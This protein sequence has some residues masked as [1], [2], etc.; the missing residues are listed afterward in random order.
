[1][2]GAPDTVNSAQQ[3]TSLLMAGAWR[4]VL[5]ALTLVALLWLAVA[6][7]MA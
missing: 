5:G 6:W 3:G 1:M 7:A 4:R 2:S